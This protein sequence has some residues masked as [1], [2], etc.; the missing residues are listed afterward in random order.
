MLKYDLTLAMDVEYMFNYF[1]YYLYCT[2]NN[3]KIVLLYGN[4]SF[5]TNTHGYFEKD[6]ENRYDI[7]RYT[8]EWP[9][10]RIE[11]AVKPP[12]ILSRYFEK[13]RCILE[14]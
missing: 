12:M 6:N 13:V 1:A 14:N 7:C 2:A 9:F 4:N 5:L 3:R 8:P 11:G 10:L